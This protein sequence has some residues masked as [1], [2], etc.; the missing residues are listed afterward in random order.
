MPAAGFTSRALCRALV[1]LVL[2]ALPPAAGAMGHP[3]TAA[4]QVGLQARGF[5]GGTIHGIVTAET[6]AAVCAFQRRHGLVADGIAGPATRAKLG[7]Y[8]RYGLGRRALRTGTQGW[9][10]A[11]LQ[12]LLAWHGFP[13]GM[14]DGAF[15]PRTDAA[16]RRY[17]RWRRLGADGIAGPSTIRAL[18]REPPPHAPVRLARPVRAPVGDRFGPRGSRFHAGIDFPARS[19]APVRA[20][21]GGI[22]AFAGWDAGGFGNLVVVRHGR[23]VRTFYAHLSRLLARRGEHVNAGDRLGTV[24]ATGF[25]T[26]PHLHLEFQVRGAAVDPLAALR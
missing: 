25:A 6:T 8:A 9:D 24:G 15:G 5:Y 4:L 18:R 19:G 10:V 16:L 2:L 17:Q 7:R 13:S 11:G 22:V 20:A 12:F 23:G 14:L 26:G 3:G 21:R 1:A